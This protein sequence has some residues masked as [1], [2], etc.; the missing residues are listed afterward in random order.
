MGR[1]RFT[2]PATVEAVFEGAAEGGGFDMYGD[3][4]PAT[5]AST[6]VE[7]RYAP[8]GMAARAGSVQ[9]GQVVLV[10]SPAELYLD[11]TGFVPDH[12][13]K[14]TIPGIGVHTVDGT[15]EVW[16]GAGVVVKL[17]KWGD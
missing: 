3:P 17:A 6:T 14:V 5:G 16:V 13:D 10:D 12:G 1:L 2:Q 4:L 8:S 15:P 7:C 9:G 11:G